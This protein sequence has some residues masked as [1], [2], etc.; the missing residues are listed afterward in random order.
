MKIN[1]DAICNYHENQ[2]GFKVLDDTIEY[3]GKL[4]GLS[5]L[6]ISVENE[7]GGIR[8]TNIRILHTG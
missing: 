3:V 6:S 4:D 7:N 1:G 8:V 2:S 5:S